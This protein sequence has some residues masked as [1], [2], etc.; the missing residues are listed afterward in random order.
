MRKRRSLLAV[1]VLLFVG[2]VA[3]YLALSRRGYATAD[4]YHICGFYYFLP[5]KSDAWRVKNY[6]CVLLFSPL[7]IVDR[8]LGFGRVPA[9]EPL[10]GL[11]R[12]Q[13]F[14]FT[15]ASIA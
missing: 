2:Y 12:T 15:K 14:H 1:V 6:G 5:E 8:W 4:R 7:N 13:S 3:S 10:W 9:S 11:S